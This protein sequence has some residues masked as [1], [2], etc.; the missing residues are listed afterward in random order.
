MRLP[1]T[2]DTP[3]YFAAEQK[4]SH[5]SHRIRYTPTPSPSPPPC[6]STV[7]PYPRSNVSEARWNEARWNEARWNESQSTLVPGLTDNPLTTDSNPGTHSATGGTSH[8]FNDHTPAIL[9][10]GLTGAG[11]STF[12]SHLTS[13]PIAVG[14]DLDSCTR[15]IAMYDAV[16]AGH[17]VR[18]IDTPGLDDTQRSDTD[19]LST[20]ATALAML[21]RTRIP[22][23]GVIY[24]HRI[25]DTR[26]GGASRKSIRLLEAICGPEAYPGIAVVTTMWDKLSNLSDGDKREEQLTTDPEFFGPLFHSSPSAITMRHTGAR[27]SAE[28]IVQELLL[29]SQERP[30]VL[31]IQ[32]Q[33]VD[34]NTALEDT[35]AGMI[36]D[37]G[38][39]RQQRQLQSELEDLE[40]SLEEAH[41]E[42]TSAQLREEQ[43]GQAQLL[44]QVTAARAGM[45][46]TWETLVEHALLSEMAEQSP[47][48]QPS[49]SGELDLQQ[50]AVSFPLPPAVGGANGADRKLADKFAELQ[51]E[52]R[53]LDLQLRDFKTEQRVQERAASKERMQRLRRFEDQ[54]KIQILQQNLQR[55][56][57]T[58]RT[59]EKCNRSL[60]NQVKLGTFILNLV[61]VAVPFAG[62]TLSS[63]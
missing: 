20:I 33:L 30:V 29:R 41:D 15:E 58:I 49:S 5:D 38:L 12:I 21:Y 50:S 10:M 14:H 8:A 60:Q 19:I 3:Q 63:F 7:P 28:A 31:Q 32:R 46:G 44:Q 22:L 45:R 1:A 16:V 51:D 62:G 4:D 11:K 57:A 9:F 13:Q 40:R 47:D 17:P 53:A 39:F 54:L 43:Q 35:A 48:D 59:L 18:L 55:S 24:L 23:A 27:V 6:Q 34:E 56:H 61:E 37:A 36:V 26:V 25:S 52:I 42:A 2:S